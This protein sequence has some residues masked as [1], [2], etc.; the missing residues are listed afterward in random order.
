VSASR[1]EVL[2]ALAVLTKPGAEVELRAIEVRAH[3]GEKP[4]PVSRCFTDPHEL[5]N[6]ALALDSYAKGIYIT[7]NPLKAG[8]AGNAQDSDI[9]ARRWLPVDIDPK[10]TTARYRSK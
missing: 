3:S 10:Q 2:H 6:E 4:H 9:A 8:T 5:A 7:L 1:D